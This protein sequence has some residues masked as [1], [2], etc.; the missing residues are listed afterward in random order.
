MGRIAV[1]AFALV[2]QA[3][4]ALAQNTFPAKPVR[5]VANIPPGSPPDVVA[6]LLSE[7]LSSALGQPVLVENRPGAS[8]AIGLNALAKAPADGYTLGVLSMPSTILPALLPVLSADTVREFAPIRQVVW[9]GNIL[10]VRA[11]APYNTLE[12]LIASAKA[13][14]G[15]LTFASGGNGTPSHIAG[16]MLSLRAGGMRHVP[17]KGAPEGVAAVMGDQVTMMLAAAGAVAPHLASGKLRALATPSPQRL[18]AFADIPTMVERGVSGVDVRDWL[19]LVAPAGTPAEVCSRLA[20]ELDRILTVPE[21]RQRFASLGMDVLE[22]SS[23]QAFHA[24]VEGEIDRWAK[25]VHDLGI[26]AD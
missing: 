14:P 22:R 6:R 23:P 26:R 17:Y 16:E 25:V 10:V 12:E 21:V 2:L 13:R 20:K 9:A 3:A 18:P 1:V 15:T 19:G 5:I 8:G 7:R 11:D 24:L 4:S